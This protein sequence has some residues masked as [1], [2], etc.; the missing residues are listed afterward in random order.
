MTRRR[1]DGAATTGED[2]GEA[3]TATRQ[4]RLAAPVPA[5]PGTFTA[6]PAW[7][8]SLQHSLS[9]LTVAAAPA[10]RPQSLTPQVRCSA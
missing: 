7:L 5:A 6:A 8:L 2:T 1:D 9:A 3:G 10:S 4:R